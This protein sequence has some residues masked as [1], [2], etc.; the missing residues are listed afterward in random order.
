MNQSSSD[1]P[2][3]VSQRKAAALKYDGQDAPRMTA[4]GSGLSAEAIIA[5]AAEHDVF[6]HEDP[7]LIDVLTQLELGDEIPEQ[8][9]LAVA[10]IIAF[11]YMLQEKTPQD[12]AKNEPK[13]K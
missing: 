11:A 3:P 7:I 12:L 1:N 10:Q 4:K 5:L 2:K 8:L 13:S 9:Y 6:I